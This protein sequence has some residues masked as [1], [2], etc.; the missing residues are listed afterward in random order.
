MGKNKSEVAP[1]RKYEKVIGNL[2]NSKQ[3]IDD[4]QSMTSYE[5]NQNLYRTNTKTLVPMEASLKQNI[6]IKD[7]ILRMRETM[8]EKVDKLWTCKVCKFSSVQACHLREHVEKHIEG[9]E[10]PCNLCGKIMRS[11]KSLRLH[12]SMKRCRFAKSDH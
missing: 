10:Y 12:H 5:D 1:E 6:H 11:S 3:N 8:F 9:V 7:D 4:S 2:N